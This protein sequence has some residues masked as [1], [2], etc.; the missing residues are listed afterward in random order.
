MD[1]VRLAPAAPPH[2]SPASYL[3][4]EAPLAMPVQSLRDGARRDPAA[5][6]SVTARRA[7]VFGI[8]FA[9]S[10]FAAYEMYLVLAVGG[11]T[12]L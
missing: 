2:D 12:T 6:I 7:F 3:P 4:A 8:T 9:L 11:L 10:V 1:A 5:A